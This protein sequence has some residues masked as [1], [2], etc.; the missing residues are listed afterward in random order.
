M[1][2]PWSVQREDLAE[3]ARV[4][5]CLGLVTAYGHVSARA[6]T[7]ML[8]TPAADLAT[9][10]ESARVEVSLDASAVPAR[11]P[12]EAWAHLALYR[13]RPDAMS[14]ARAQP[15]SGF[16]A[17]ATGISLLPVYGQAAWLGETIPV[18]GGAHLHRQ[19]MAVGWVPDTSD[20]DGALRR[21]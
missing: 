16:A 12:A 20:P 21:W 10:S 13:A 4:L 6:A 8:I 19:P 1:G 7:S 3:A 18:H 2:N 9:I 14:V 15:E 5:S 11:A 17:A